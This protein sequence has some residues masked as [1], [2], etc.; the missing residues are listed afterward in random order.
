MQT[1]SAQRNGIEHEWKLEQLEKKS[2]KFI[3]TNWSSHLN[4]LFGMKSIPL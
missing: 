3:T 2:M 1:N 4:L